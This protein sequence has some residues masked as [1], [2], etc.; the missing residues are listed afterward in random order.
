ML[1]E[2]QFS[3]EAD[4]T[5]PDF[6]VNFETY[7]DRR[8]LECETL[9]PL[10]KIDCGETACHSEVWKLYDNVKNPEFGNEEEVE[11]ILSELK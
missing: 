5:Y 10:T 2:K 4:K 6:N 3:Y 8:I 11:K 7:S 1:F 9:A